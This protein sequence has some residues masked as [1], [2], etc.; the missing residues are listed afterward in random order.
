MEWKSLIKKSCVSFKFKCVSVLLSK[1][2]W[3]ELQKYLKL[4]LKING[5]N[6]TAQWNL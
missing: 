6:Y 3:L 2:L 4:S 5:I 1:K